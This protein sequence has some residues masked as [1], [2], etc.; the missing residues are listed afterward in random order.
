MEDY[1]GL[2]V[3]WGFYPEKGETITGRARK[4]GRYE[5]IEASV[6]KALNKLGDNAWYARIIR[7]ETYNP[8]AD[9]LRSDVK[10][11]G[12]ISDSAQNKEEYELELLTGK[13]RTKPVTKI[14]IS[15]GAKE[16]VLI[17][18]QFYVI[19]DMGANVG[20]RD[21]IDPETGRAVGN[22]EIKIG[23]NS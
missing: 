23:R 15:A 11:G 22:A 16:G 10:N 21:L 4:A 18:D 2:E 14:Y 12:I 9:V 6:S 7:I 19:R 13:K 5:A 1:R 17:N 3:K 8:S 20:A